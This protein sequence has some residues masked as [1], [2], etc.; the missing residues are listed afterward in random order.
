M[1]KEIDIDTFQIVKQFNL[2][3]NDIYFVNLSKKCIPV[4][5]IVIY[6]NNRCFIF[7]NYTS[8]LIIDSFDCPDD[9]IHVKVDENKVLSIDFSVDQFHNNFNECTGYLKTLLS[10]YEHMKSYF[11]MI[12]W[13]LESNKELI[14]CP[15]Q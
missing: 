3:K 11:S 13:I 10:N 8:R 9:Q 12:A 1:M 15:G 6:R 4:K 2:S 14:Y 5:I 7:F